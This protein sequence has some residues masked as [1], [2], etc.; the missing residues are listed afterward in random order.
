MGA[1]CD[2]GKT[3]TNSWHSLRKIPQFYL[4]SWCE[5]FGEKSQFPHSFGRIARNY[6]ETVNFSKISIPGNQGELTVFFAVIVNQTKNEMV[7]SLHMIL[8]EVLGLEKR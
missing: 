4:I 1:A 2:D 6:A 7:S 5:T 8:Q 3:E